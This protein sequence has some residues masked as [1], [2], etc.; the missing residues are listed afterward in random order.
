MKNLAPSAFVG[1]FT[2]EMQNLRLVGDNTNKGEERIRKNPR[3]PSI[4]EISNAD[5]WSKKKQSRDLRD[6]FSKS[7]NPPRF[8]SPRNSEDYFIIS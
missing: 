1:V 5:H 4:R 6:C 2:N 3:N 8:V 7:V